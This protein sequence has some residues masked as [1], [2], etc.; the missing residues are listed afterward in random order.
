M[1][2]STAYQKWVILLPE[3]YSLTSE[4]GFTPFTEPEVVA[5]YL[6]P[7]LER[8]AITF[9]SAC[10]RTQRM[11]I[12]RRWTVD[13]ALGAY[14]V[15]KEVLESL[16]AQGVQVEEEDLEVERKSL[17]GLLLKLPLVHL[18]IRKSKDGEIPPAGSEQ[19][20]SFY[21]W[22]L[23]VFPQGDD[24]KIVP[25]HLMLLWNDNSNG[26][27]ETLLL[28]CV[29]GNNWRWR[30]P[31]F[32]RHADS[33][34]ASSSVEHSVPIESSGDQ[35][36]PFTSAFDAGNE[37]VPMKLVQDVPS[38]ESERI[39]TESNNTDEQQDQDKKKA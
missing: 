37:D 28:V 33:A 13:A 24:E 30:N 32:Q 35:T 7:L 19:S 2:L 12:E 10:D 11:F 25:L 26:E 9:S 39:E 27:L 34:R 18:K 20:L 14:L 29:E 6:Q 3:G 21:N 22:N 36:V 15:R 5:A 4:G 1:A 8:L 17:C 38:S 23:L 16:R 31:V